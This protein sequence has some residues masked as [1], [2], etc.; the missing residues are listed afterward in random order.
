MRLNEESKIKKSFEEV[1][2]HTTSEMI[3]SAFEKQK[4][5]SMLLD[6]KTKKRPS[7]WFSLTIGFSSV[8]LA[9]SSIAGIAVLLNNQNTYNPIIIS[10]RH[11]QAAFELYTGVNLLSYISNNTSPELKSLGNELG[12]MNDE[13]VEKP[14]TASVFNEVVEKYHQNHE[15]YTS[16]LTKGDGIQ[17]QVSDGPFVGDYDTYQYQMLIEESYYF[18]YSDDFAEQDDESQYYGEIRVGESDAYLVSFKIEQNIYTNK[19]EVEITINLD[20]NSSLEIEFATKPNRYSYEY[21]YVENGEETKSIE[22][23][24][25]GKNNGLML[26]ID[27]EEGNLNFSYKVRTIEDNNYRMNY[28]YDNGIKTYSGVIT[29]TVYSNSIIYTET[30]LQISIL[31]EIQ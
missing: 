7:L 4:I 28:E 20:E 13:V 18:Y 27:I 26:D 5:T 9:C 2:I 3:L 17:Y 19:N 11:L 6:T 10:D 16:L 29:Y 21:A 14:I 25:K 23:E 1:K 22:I 15:L 24:L 31:K 8:A 30:H 12:G